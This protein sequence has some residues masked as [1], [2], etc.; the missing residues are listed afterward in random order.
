MKSPKLI[1]EKENL[2]ENLNPLYYKQNI[3]QEEFEAFKDSVLEYLTRIYNH[4]DTKAE[5]W[6]VSNALLPFLEN[7][8]FKGCVEA[9]YHQNKTNKNSTIDLVL[10]NSDNSVEVIFEVKIPNNRNEMFSTQNTTAKAMCEAILY[11]IRE[12]K[13]GN[14]DLK[15]IILTDFFN[16][17][18]FKAKEFEKLFYKNPHIKKIYNNKNLISNNKDFYD[19]LE[20]LLHSEKFFSGIT[21]P[22]DDDKGLWGKFLYGLHID[23]RLFENDSKKYKNIFK[24]FHRDYL[25]SEY[26]PDSNRI[27]Q[28]FFDELLFVLGLKQ[29]SKT[30]KIGIDTAQNISL[31]R[32]I[33]EKLT[34][35]L[36]DSTELFDK[37]MELLIIWLN[38]I[39]F[40]KLIETNLSHFNGE[41][42]F[43]PFLTKEKIKDFKTLEHLFFEV[44]AKDYATRKEDKGFNYIPYLN[45]SLFLRK[46]LES[47]FSIKDLD[48]F[49]ITPYRNTQV[50][51]INTHKKITEKLPF[52]AYLFDFLNAF[53]FGKDFEK[54]E[55]EKQTQ[56]AQE[57]GKISDSDNAMDSRVLGLVFENLNG[58]KEGSFYTPGFITEYMCKESLEKIILDKFNKLF[59]ANAQDLENAREFLKL[60]LKSGN[61]QARDQLKE[62]LLSIKVC[63]PSVGSGH[64]LASALNYLC[65][66]FDYFN[67]VDLENIN[68]SVEND[69]LKQGFHY[70][71]PNDEKEQNHKNQ[72]ALFNLKRQIIESCLFGVDINPISCEITRLRLWIELLKNSYY[73]FEKG[74]LDSNIHKLETLPNIDI[75]IKC[76]NS[77]VAILDTNITLENFT[78]K[79]DEKY[80]KAQK[81]QNLF[82][83]KSLESYINDIKKKASI[84]F[85]ELKN[86]VENYK[87]ETDKEKALF[88]KKE[89]ERAY[90]YLKEL[91]KRN[92]DEYSNFYRA[93]KD[94][95]YQYGYVN[96]LNLDLETKITLESYVESFEFHKSVDYERENHRKIKQKE[97]EN[98]LNLLKDYE[99]FQQLDSFEWRFAFPEVLD[100]N[101]DFLGFDL[102]IGNPPY[103]RQEEIKH[104]K[105]Q[106][107]KAFRIY[108]GT[109]DIYTYFYEQGHKILKHN[110]ILS[111]ITSNKY[112]RAGYGEPLREFLL[113]AT[114]LLYYI[115]LNG[116]KV[117]DSASVDTSILSFIKTTPDSTHTFDFAHPKD[118]DT[119][120][121]APLQ[122]YITPQSLLQSSL[123][124]ESFIF[125][126]STNAALKAKI[127]AIGT[128]LKEWDISINYGI[129]T[130]YNEA[131]IIDSTKRDEI[132][133]NCVSENE[134][135][136]TSELIKPILRGRDIKRYSYEW[137]GLWIIG[138]FPALKLNIDDYPALR[139]YLESYRPR[140]DQ[141]GEKGC[142]KKTSNKWFETQDNIAYYQ[143][144]EK[145]KIVWNRISSELCFSYDNSSHTILDS[146]FMIT[147]NC[148]ITTKYLLATLNSSISKNWIKNN[149]A[150]LGDGIYGAKIYIEKL[151]VPQI[152]ESN[153]PLCD[154]IIKCVDRILEIK[155]CHTEALAEVSKNTESKKDFSPF[156]KAQNDKTDSTLDTSKLES[157]LDSLVYTLYNLTNDEIETI[158]GKQ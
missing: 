2:E 131:F 69:T 14:V 72:K 118:Y 144:F 11:Y 103:I 111:F 158:K 63:D 136:R 121:N 85:S 102:V 74:K 49:D 80:K 75:N 154:E 33:Q 6:L 46:A 145:E 40:L 112:C 39:L 60:E 51:D 18:I 62:A 45:S 93:L 21:P 16:F 150:T 90:F 15:F 132:L 79:L 135:Q 68:L 155:A 153:K 43:Q 57:K 143:E 104:L 26:R 134:R 82:V 122:E 86:S 139:N 3:E 148:Q 101:G 124:Q 157:K 29:D 19:E 71:R 138:T 22:E 110:G 31:I 47:H 108:K 41:N 54:S 115:E 59:S 106:L 120:A 23:L 84:K 156:S 141:S 95:F 12:R 25:L 55:Q 77:L 126:D 35:K 61:T 92:C 34:E 38:R 66:Y 53:D 97:L 76:G 70:K 9:Q 78:E 8:G 73:I 83:T 151:P 10:K 107:Q 42:G 109:S 27:N 127:E 56:E 89:Y 147:S 28:R 44:L 128:P 52:L 67:L 64:F 137:A 113:E 123:T 81:S 30:N 48:N 13:N 119:K 17:Y 100:S 91:F 96:F 114:A 105:P 146:M 50:R 65:Y 37:S 7:V 117:F 5:T 149:S 94:F 58:F 125:Q 98:L 130:G 88:Y 4:K 20:K 87:N 152:T 99:N 24:V 32:I 36:G 133:R 140:I 129:K 116:I 142:R 1:F